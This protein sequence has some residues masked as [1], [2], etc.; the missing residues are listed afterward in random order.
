MSSTSISTVSESPALAHTFTHSASLSPETALDV[1]ASMQP[2]PPSLDA[3]QQCTSISSLR[4]ALSALCRGHGELLRL[5]IVPAAQA[6]KQQAL[7][8]MRMQTLAQEHSLMRA[9]GIGRFGGEM[10]L[11]VSLKPWLSAGNAPVL[12]G[13]RH[14]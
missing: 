12:H 4:V 11:V 1:P 14:H 6:G 13:D 10:V 3:L 9:L 8:L 5:D 7:C 2:S